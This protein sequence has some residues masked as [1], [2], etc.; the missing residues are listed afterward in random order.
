MENIGTLLRLLMRHSYST[1]VLHSLITLF[2]ACLSL[3]LP[4]RSLAAASS[5]TYFEPYRYNVMAARFTPDS[6]RIVALGDSGILIEWDFLQ[7]QIL[8]KV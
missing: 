1:R 2:V 7:N 6:K 5:Y 8:P 3:V 4:D